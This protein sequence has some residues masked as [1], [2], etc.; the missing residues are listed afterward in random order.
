MASPPDLQQIIKDGEAAYRALSIF[1]TARYKVLQHC[2][3]LPA[4]N[5]NFSPPTTRATG[6]MYT[7]KIT[8]DCSV[9]H[10]RHSHANHKSY[11]LHY[12]SLP[13]KCEHGF[14]IS[15][16]HVQEDSERT[17]PFINLPSQ[18]QKVAPQCLSLSSGGL[19]TPDKLDRDKQRIQ[20]TFN[21]ADEA[22]TTLA[23]SVRSSNVDPSAYPQYG[24]DHVN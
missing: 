4:T 12:A 22:F 2:N 18:I 1:E 10:N 24:A 6:R 13:F 7:A 9:C 3:L 20:Q 8:S 14:T 17:L 11:L 23:A 15:N 21:A 19:T 5:L 16:L